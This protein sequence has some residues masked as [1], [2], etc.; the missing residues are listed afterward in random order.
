MSPLDRHLGRY[1]CLFGG[2]VLVTLVCVSRA[3][4]AS[5]ESGLGVEQRLLRIVLS[6]TKDA[7]DQTNLATLLRRVKQR[8]LRLTLSAVTDCA[9]DLRQGLREVDRL[10]QEASRLYREGALD[11]D[12]FR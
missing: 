10:G 12:Q 7:G 2:L 11:R 4:G 8:K 3:A 5:N 9:S 1:L 6:K